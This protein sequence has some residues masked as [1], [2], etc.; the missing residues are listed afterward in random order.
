MAPLGG[1]LPRQS[2]DLP[3]QGWEPGTAAFP[4]RAAYQP[5][6]SFQAVPPSSVPITSPGPVTAGYPTIAPPRVAGPRRGLLAPIALALVLLLLIVTALQSAL[7]WDTR[8]DLAAAEKRNAA[9]RVA[10]EER[11]RGLEARTKELE[12]RAGNTL[13]AASVAKDVLPSVFRVVT[14]AGLGTGFAFGPETPG[15]GTQLL[16][17]FH[18]VEAVWNRGGREVV[19]E[20]Q[21]R[22]F[23]AQVVKVDVGADLALLGSTERFPRLQASQEAAKPGQ[24]VVVVGSPQGLDDSVTSGVVSALRSSSRGAVLQFDAAVNPGNSG[25]PVVNAQ[26]QV[27][28]VVNAKIDNAEGLSLGI[29][30]A[31]VC[32]A[33]GLC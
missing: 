11:E 7:L 3:R 23:T 9:A 19:L 27:V 25:G 32:E 1:D 2:G 17:N 29:P 20:Q 30:V 8:N 18:V 33:F 5:T 6:S 28:G 13:D 24:P 14:P 15:G 21:N 22:R 16:T 10:A 4:G 12:Q 26:K 31:V